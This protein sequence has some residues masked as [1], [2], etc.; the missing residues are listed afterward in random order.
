M[1]IQHLVDRLEQAL[2]ESFRLPL[3]AYLLVNEDRIF[4]IVDQMRV[5]IPEE[6]KRANRI[7]AEKDRI[8]AQ[9]KEEA[10]R[11]RD[12]AKQEAGELVRRDSVTSSAQQ[13]ADNILERAR[14][15]AEALRHDADA[16]VAE[17]LTRLE[18]DLLRSLNVVRNGLHKVQVEHE[19]ADMT[20]SD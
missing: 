10:E 20:P 12:L 6:V 9:A 18:E 5:A 13:R 17:V 7:E 8:L 11:I 14:R 4:N 19:T 16:Y 15:D 1:D 3:S 2:N